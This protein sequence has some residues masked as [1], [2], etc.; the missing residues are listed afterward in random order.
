MESGAVVEVAWG[1]LDPRRPLTL[2]QEARE[3][4]IIPYV[5]EL[6]LPSEAIITYNQSIPNIAGIYT[7]PS[8]LES[9]C[10]VFIHGLGKICLVQYDFKVF[11][12]SVPEYLNRELWT[13][14]SIFDN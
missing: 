6:M 4:G 1:L 3:E 9:T 12:L 8:A 13:I 7:S 11:R 2:T 10:L 14:F 5:P